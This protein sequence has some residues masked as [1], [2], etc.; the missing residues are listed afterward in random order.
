MAIYI[1]YS[2]FTQSKWRFSIVFCRFTRGYLQHPDV[3]LEFRRCLDDH[4]LT[5][6]IWAISR[7]LILAGTSPVFPKT[8]SGIAGYGRSKWI[9]SYFWE[10]WNIYDI[11]GE[12]FG[13]WL[14]K[15]FMELW[16]MNG[17][18]LPYFGPD[19]SGKKW[20]SQGL[21]W[22]IQDSVDSHEIPWNPMNPTSKKWVSYVFSE[23]PLKHGWL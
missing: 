20:I 5:T 1:I 19:L 21:V 6:C 12:I 2:W 13:C 23:I 14:L 16:M 22:R 9:L 3:C 15:P 7:P 8:W 10:L 11:F 4:P 17:W 18:I